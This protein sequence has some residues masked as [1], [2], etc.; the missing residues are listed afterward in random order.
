MKSTVTTAVL[1]LSS[2]ASAFAPAPAGVHINNNAAVRNAHATSSNNWVQ[3]RATQL[4]H[5]T[6]TEPEAEVRLEDRNVPIAHAGE[7]NYVKHTLARHVVLAA[8]L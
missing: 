1:L 6:K 2:S 4:Q 8:I 3:R 5:S 7:I